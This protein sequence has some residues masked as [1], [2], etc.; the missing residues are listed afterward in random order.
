[1]S[2]TDPPDAP[3]G[4][5]PEAAGQTD[6]TPPP[7]ERSLTNPEPRPPLPAALAAQKSKMRK[8]ILSYDGR[9]GKV[10]GI[11][12]INMFLS[13]L[14]LG[15]YSFWGKTRLRRYLVSSMAINGKE[16][17]EYTGT[18]KELLVGWLKAM[19]V[20]APVLAAFIWADV[21]K[22]NLVY[23]I[24]GFAFYVLFFAG[25][26]LALRYRLSRTKWRGIRFGLA[27]NTVDYLKICLKRLFFNIVT[28][29]YGVAK[30]DIEKWTYMANNMY[31]GKTKFK[32][33]GDYKKLTWI[34]MITMWLP[35]VPIVSLALMIG[36]LSPQ[37]DAGLP[38]ESAA[39]STTKMAFLV[40]LLIVAAISGVFGR[41]WY[42]AALR[43]ERFAGLALEGIRFKSTA[44]G[45]DYL[46]LKMMNLLILV[47]T[48]GYGFAIVLNRNM[49]F[50]CRHVIIGGDLDALIS[51]QADPNRKSDI[52][53]SL[54]PDLDLGAA[55]AI[56]I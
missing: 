19:V 28:L 40:I 8:N 41:L 6:Q 54:A 10:F 50:E 12:L 2:M 55:L 43:A 44:T 56:G 52:G 17:F 23:C 37:A 36:T 34:N 11:M 18:P 30:S 27:G 26:Y 35:L 31:F 33:R 24:A 46:K 53:D 32:Y 4:F 39:A 5:P 38:E 20:F 47:I 14:T 51:A 1:M 15:I 25:T 22:N 29:G 7:V 3:A 42:R 45:K 9:A 21:V 49:K 16:R 48:I 13:F